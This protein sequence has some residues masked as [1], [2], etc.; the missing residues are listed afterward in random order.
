MGEG[1]ESDQGSEGDDW[2]GA[3]ADDENEEGEPGAAGFQDS[4]MSGE[5]GERVGI[6]REGEFV[7]KLNDPKLPS[8]KE[9]EE[10]RIRGHIPYRSWCPLCVEAMGR[11]RGHYR[12]GKKERSFP[13]YSWD[14]CFPGDEFG[15]HWTVL[16]GK[17]RN[18]GAVMAVTVPSKGGGH[19]YSMD[20]TLEFIKENGDQGGTILV[21]SDQEA[22]V[23][24]VI[25]RVM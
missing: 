18:S 17:E 13:E 1:E 10:H 24:Y 4:D 2:A 25:E 21:K 6:E 15:Y 8:E 12:G 22:S 19:G 9:V 23:K 7:R 5:S 14:Y 11:E 20:K 16:V 3:Q